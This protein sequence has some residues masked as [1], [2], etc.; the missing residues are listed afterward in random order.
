MSEYKTVREAITSSFKY[1][2]EKVNELNA[3]LRILPEEVLDT[4]VDSVTESIGSIYLD[5]TD[6]DP[7]VIGKLMGVL[8]QMNKVR[9]DRS[10]TE[11]RKSWN[12]EIQLFEGVI[13]DDDD[14]VFFINLRKKTGLG[15]DCKRYKVRKTSEY[16]MVICGE[17]ELDAETEILEVISE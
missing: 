2:K 6:T 4:K 12:P 17:P 3:A 11:W 10:V 15:A 16:E 9:Y 13:G 8:H 14:N 1:Y 7:K 5:V